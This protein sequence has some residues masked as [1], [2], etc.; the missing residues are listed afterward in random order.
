VVAV[1]FLQEGIRADS[2]G[3][4]NRAGPL[5]VCS[6]FVTENSLPAQWNRLHIPSLLWLGDRNRRT[7]SF[8]PVGMY[9][10]H[11][12][13]LFGTL[14]RT[15]RTDQRLTVGEFYEVLQLAEAII[16]YAQMIQNHEMWSGPPPPYILVE[17]PELASR[18]RETPRAIKSALLLLKN[19]GRATPFKSRIWKVELPGAPRRREDAEVA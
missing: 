7:I 9:R 16:D 10:E 8:G 15:L 2:T 5:S 19:M 18:F 14:K 12:R 1:Q 13:R 3:C 11:L 17:I 4:G 6:A